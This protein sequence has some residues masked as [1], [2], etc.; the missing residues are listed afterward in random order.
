[1]ANLTDGAGL[2]KSDLVGIF[3]ETLNLVDLNKA[4]TTSPAV[5][6][7]IHWWVPQLIRKVQTNER[8]N[9]RPGESLHYASGEEG[10]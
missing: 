4:E 3:S 6:M 5:C 9:F 2:S 8:K 1:M 7:S 10:G